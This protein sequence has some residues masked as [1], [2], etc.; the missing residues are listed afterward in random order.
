MSRLHLKLTID[1]CV[2]TEIN[3]VNEIVDNMGVDIYPNDMSDMLIE[4][5]NII[6]AELT[7]AR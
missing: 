4:D 1:V 2:D 3:N 6:G 5:Y 7:D